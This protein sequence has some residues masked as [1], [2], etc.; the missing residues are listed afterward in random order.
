MKPAPS[1]L[2]IDPASNP[3]LECVLLSR[4]NNAVGICLFNNRFLYGTFVLAPGNV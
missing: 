4:S 3:N 1:T 2:N